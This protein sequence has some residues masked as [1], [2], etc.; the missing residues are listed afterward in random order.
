MAFLDWL[1]GKMECPRCGTHGA[2]EI[3]GAI[4]CPNPNCSY[5]SM[6]MG[7]AEPPSAPVTFITPQANESGES[8]FAA[9]VDVPAGSF[10]IR[11]RDFQ[12]KERTFIAETSSAWRNKNHIHVKVAP[13]GAR[14]VLSR[15]RILNLSDVSAAFPQRVAPGQDW[16]S[17]RERQVMT[18]HKKHGTTSALYETIRAKYPDW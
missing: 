8:P 3:N 6:T 17:P 12:G 16:P 2:K 9:P 13:K 1:T 18:Y 11:Y 5:F 15:D 10:A 7:K 14:I 4:H